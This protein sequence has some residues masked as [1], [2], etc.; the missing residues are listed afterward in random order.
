MRF[1][2]RGVKN[3]PIALAKGAENRLELKAAYEEYLQKKREKGQYAF[4][5]RRQAIMR[6]GLTTVR[7]HR[8]ADLERQ[9]KEWALRFKEKKKILPELSAIIIIYVDPHAAHGGA[10]R[11]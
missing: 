2:K 11:G 10:N 1:L 7:Q 8:L 6:I 5:I 4:Q 3:S 9:E